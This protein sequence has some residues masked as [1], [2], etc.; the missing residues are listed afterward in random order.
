M[1]RVPAEV[2][3]TLGSPI[4]AFEAQKVEGHKRGLRLAP[5]GHE[6]TEVAPPAVVG[7]S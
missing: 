3:V 7:L 2:S 1:R 5:P 6:R 4:V